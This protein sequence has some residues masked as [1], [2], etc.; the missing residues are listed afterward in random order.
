MLRPAAGVRLALALCNTRIPPPI[1]VCAN[2]EGGWE[3]LHM[4]PTA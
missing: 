1:I 3:G 2:N 4:L